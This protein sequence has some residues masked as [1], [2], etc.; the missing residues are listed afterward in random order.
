MNGRELRTSLEKP[1]TQPEIVVKKAETNL[2]QPEISQF[3][4]R[5]FRVYQILTSILSK[6]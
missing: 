5:L 6:N 1:E 4:L 3:E 2:R